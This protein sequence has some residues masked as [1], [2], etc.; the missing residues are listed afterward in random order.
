MRYTVTWGGRAGEVR[1]FAVVPEI[2]GRLVTV[3]HGEAV[4]LSEP[5]AQHLGRKVKLIPITKK[6]EAAEED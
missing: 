4:E 2:S 1:A 3:R 6:A 5:E